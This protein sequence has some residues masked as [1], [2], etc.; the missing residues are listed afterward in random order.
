MKIC[1]IHWYSVYYE[2]A[3]D[4]SPYFS[5]DDKKYVWRQNKPF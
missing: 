1:I 2:T 4:L 5:S 3:F